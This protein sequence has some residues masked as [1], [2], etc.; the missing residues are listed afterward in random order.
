MVVAQTSCAVLVSEVGCILMDNSPMA[1]IQIS[2]DLSFCCEM[3]MFRCVHIFL[4]AS[5]TVAFKFGATYPEVEP[6]MTIASSENISEED[7]PMLLEILSE[8]A[9]STLL[10]LLFAST[11]LCDLG[12]TTILWVLIFAISWSRA[13]LCDFVQPKVKAQL[14]NPPA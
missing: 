3:F 7:I 14:W 1:V 13:K 12:L 10:L 8:T 5:V 11:K 4:P 2:S 9:S 6:E